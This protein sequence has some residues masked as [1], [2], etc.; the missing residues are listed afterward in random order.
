MEQRCEATFFKQKYFVCD[1]DSIYDPFTKSIDQY[2][3]RAKKRIYGFALLS[4]LL[5]FNSGFFFLLLLI[6]SIILQQD[7]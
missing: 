3:K 5:N 4:T 6:P 1:R 7:L 2:F